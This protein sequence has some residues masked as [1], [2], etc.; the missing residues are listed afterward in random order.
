MANVTAT[1]ET[2]K[3]ST[4]LSASS[5]CYLFVENTGTTAETVNVTNAAGEPAY[6]ILEYGKANLS[7]SV[8]PLSRGGTAKVKLGATLSANVEVCAGADGRAI[9]TATGYRVCGRLLAGGVANDIV[10]I[11]IYQGRIVP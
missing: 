6:G 5:N 9:A 2:R 3:T 11:D 8:W 1:P 10:E 7:A 4:D